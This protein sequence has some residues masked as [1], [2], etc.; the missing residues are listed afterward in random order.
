[1][2][3]N[4]KVKGKKIILSNLSTNSQR[5]IR[6]KISLKTGRNPEKYEKILEERKKRMQEWRQW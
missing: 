5:K 2:R 3:I 6:A 1:M 4:K